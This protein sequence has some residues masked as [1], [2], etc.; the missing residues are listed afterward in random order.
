MKV[1]V[2]GSLSWAMEDIKETDVHVAGNCTAREMLNQLV[3]AHPGLKEKVFCEGQKLQRGVNL[4]VGDCS[5][6]V[7]DGL[8]TL[9]EEGDELILLPLLCG[10]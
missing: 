3:I 4:F 5:I 9:L 1:R 8:S 2:L 7:L 10:G 6:R